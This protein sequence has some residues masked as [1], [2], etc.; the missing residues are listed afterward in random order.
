MTILNYYLTVICHAKTYC[1]LL[2]SVVSITCD[3]F[4][5]FSK[6]ILRSI[7]LS[8][9][10]QIMIPIYAQGNWWISDLTPKKYEFNE[11]FVIS[12]RSTII[13]EKI[14]KVFFNWNFSWYWIRRGVS[15]L[16]N[17]EILHM[18]NFNPVAR[19][20]DRNWK[21]MLYFRF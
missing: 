5:S 11:N 8:K 13:D 2:G 15:T 16:L 6:L 10:N 21:N 14:A 3:T 18:S 19:Q 20:P 7:F 4:P 9:F 17:I 1:W 12:L